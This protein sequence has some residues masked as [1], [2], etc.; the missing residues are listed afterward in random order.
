MERI[1]RWMIL[2]LMIAVFGFAGCSQAPEEKAEKSAPV[3]LETIPETGLNRV[4]LTEKAAERLGIQT[5]LVRAEQNGR[6]RIAWGEVVALPEMQAGDPNIARV[7]VSLNGSDTAKVDRSQFALVMLLD[8][9]EDDGIEAEPDDEADAEDDDEGADELY[10]R[11]GN[12]DQRLAIGQR[13][14]VVVPLLAAGTQG[15]VVP[16]SSVIYDLDGATWVYT[17]P[18]P[19]VFVRYPIVVDYIEGDQAYLVEGPPAGTEV[20]TVGV[21]ELYGADTGVGK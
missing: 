8:E 12:A 16:Y 4:V 17:S 18:E 13:V 14:R 20:A 6:K 3:M 7:S 15:T 10:Y 9:E 11:V 21:A 2:V 19:L 1:N 5:A